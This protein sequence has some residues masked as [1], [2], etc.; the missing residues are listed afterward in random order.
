MKKD[1]REFF[2]G[3]VFSCII[4]LAIFFLIY[5]LMYVMGDPF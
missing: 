1:D 2:E 3:V 5:G 4:L